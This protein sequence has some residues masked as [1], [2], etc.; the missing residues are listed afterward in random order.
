MGNTDISVYKTGESR[1]TSYS[2]LRHSFILDLCRCGSRHRDS[3]PPQEAGVWIRACLSY[4]LFVYW[5]HYMYLRLSLLMMAVGFGT[6]LRQ[7]LI[8]AGLVKS[9]YKHTFLISGHL[10]HRRR[11]MGSRHTVSGHY[12][13]GYSLRRTSRLL[14]L[15]SKI[16]LPRNLPRKLP[17]TG[18]E[19]QSHVNDPISVTINPANNSKFTI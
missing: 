1:D 18:K 2:C 5:W 4:D 11:W 12:T 13:L 7:F 3:L 14:Y 19:H 6:W 17:Q 16:P 10:W 15:R 9:A 8:V